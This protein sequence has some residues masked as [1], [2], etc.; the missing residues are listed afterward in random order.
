MADIMTEQNQEFTIVDEEDVLARFE[1]FKSRVNER[2]HAQYERMRVARGFLS[3]ETQWDEGDN[4]Y[5][6]EKRNRLT[7]NVV[8]NNVASTANSYD[9][10]PFQWYTGEWEK[11]QALDKFLGKPGN[12][13][14]S[15]EALKEAI[16]VGLGVMCVGTEESGAP[17]IYT[18]P[19]FERVM[20]D[21][22][23]Y[24]LTGEDMCECALIDYRGRNW[25]RLHYGEEYLPNKE[26]MN[27]VPCK[28]GLIPVVT[29]YVMEEG[30]VRVYELVNQ[31]VIDKG[32]MQIPRIPVFPVYG[33]IYIRKDGERAF[34][35][36]PEKA[37]DI[38]RL[39][40]YAYTQLGERLSLSPKPQFIGTV[41]AF[42]DL[43]DYYK[44]AAAGINPMLPYNR[45]SKDRKEDLQPPQRFDMNVQ[46]QDLAGIIGETLGLMGSVTGVDSRGMADA[47]QQKTATE[48]DYTAHVFA[49]NVR[50]YYTHLKFSFKAM[51]Q[52]IADMVGMDSQIEICQGPDEMMQRQVAR[53]E[54]GQLLGVAEPNQ[55][56]PIINAI[57]QSHPDN[58]I[59]G[60]LYAELNSIPQPTM[61][62]Q[63]MQD[64]IEQMK[65]AIEERDAKMK[66]MQDIIDQYD[67]STQEQ[68]KNIEFE[69]AKMKLQHQYD[70][71]NKVV[72]A[73]L[74][75]GTDT[76]KVAN[77]AERA[78]IKVES[79]AETAAI[80]AQSA[81]D[82]LVFQRLKNGIDLEKAQ[83]DNQVQIDKGNIEV[84]KSAA[85]ADQAV[86]N[87]RKQGKKEKDN[88]D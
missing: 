6:S 63:Q 51:G 48:V 35:G 40:N 85:L 55:K 18:V 75:A 88:A 26:A 78:R 15:M 11:D 13:S 22:D 2:F 50:H 20:L 3:G 45:K 32:L 59:L 65:L 41:E 70:I 57:L 14:C 81:K 49:A 60:Q 38:Q 39:V 5:I 83:I 64:T 30:G 28:P 36:I 37:K 47:T 17:A 73:Q 62:E 72:D 53:Q 29:Y 31:R 23:S 1:R 27:I 67:K 42:K 56:G 61:M 34:R 74:D 80:K 33:E 12:C 46:F 19:D 68:D 71:E 10:Y 21:P 43:D 44:Q 77:E 58:E 7:V 16:S 87:A 69:L 84:A 24:D 4:R 52:F 54:L 82:Q 86:K 66:E 8:A 76:E 9:E 79:E 25:I